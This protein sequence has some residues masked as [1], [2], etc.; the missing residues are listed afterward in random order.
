MNQQKSSKSTTRRVA[1]TGMMI[2]VTI[3]MSFTP[4]GM[5]PTPLGT[6]TVSHL[7]TI[8]LAILEGP[9]CGLISGAV[10]GLISMWRAIAM[11]QSLLDP[12][13]RN[14]L[15]SVLPRM[16]IGLTS[17][18]VY[19]GIG[20]LLKNKKAKNAV[21]VVAGAAV[22]SITNTVG[23]LGMLYLIELKGVF[24]AIVQM[25]LATQSDESVGAVIAFV[26]AVATTVGVAEMAVVAAIAAVVILALKRAGYGRKF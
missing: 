23:V 2:A 4:V 9:I 12:L 1:I 3:L 15:I 21:S 25:G 10:M 11:P 18:Y 6:A 5:I 14:P 8:I 24:D 22:G 7:P 17:Y 20:T 26:V 13:F 19:T 16:L